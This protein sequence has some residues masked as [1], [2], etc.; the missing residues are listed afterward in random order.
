VVNTAAALMGVRLVITARS[1]RRGFFLTPA[2]IPET[3]KSLGYVPDV[4][5]KRTFD[6]AGPE[7]GG[8]PE[9]VGGE[10]VEYR[11]TVGS[12]SRGFMANWSG[13]G[14]VD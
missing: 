3:R 10:V 8:K 13:R 7:E 6:G 9:F 12:R 4:G 2:W 1:R 14:K 5:M 11:L